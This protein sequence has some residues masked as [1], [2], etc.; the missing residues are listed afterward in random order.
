MWN[1]RSSILPSFSI[2]D[3]LVSN[4][5]NADVMRSVNFVTLASF[6]WYLLV[7]TVAMPL[8]LIPARETMPKGILTGRLI[9]VLNIA[10]LD[11]PEA[12]LRPLEQAFSDVSRSKALEYFSCFSHT[13]LLALA[14]PIAF[15]EPHFGGRILG[16]KKLKA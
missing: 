3:T 14:T 8:T 9:N 6:F 4:T 5:A 16:L 13:F 15:L 2:L 1:S 11:I 12:T 7:S 10:T